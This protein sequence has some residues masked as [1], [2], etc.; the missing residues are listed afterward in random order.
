MI[1]SD[2]EA[3]VFVDNYLSSVGQTIQSLKIRANVGLRNKL[4]LELKARSN[5]SIRQI[6]ELLGIDRNIVQRVK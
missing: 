5:L 4:I 2:K 3:S 1:S 6:A